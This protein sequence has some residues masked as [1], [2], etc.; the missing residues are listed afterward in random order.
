MMS[1][2]VINRSYSEIRN[3]CKPEIAGCV[4]YAERLFA[5]TASVLTT[6][7]LLERLDARGIRNNKIAEV[8]GVHPSRVTEMYKGE[9]V[10]KLDEA[11][12]LVAEF[13]LESPQGQRV[14][15]LPAP[16]ARL[17]VQHIA[18]QL[19]Y[20]LRDDSP[21]LTDLCED[22]RAFFEFVTDPKVR[23]SIDLAMAFFQA[24]RLRRPISEEAN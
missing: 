11:A 16:V 4:I 24:L 23:G 20:P 8:L 17:I 18:L 5:Q 7:E 6:K 19:G 1:E 13:D 21:Q 2:A 12:K 9:R 14:S 3:S 15:P 22:L 10:V